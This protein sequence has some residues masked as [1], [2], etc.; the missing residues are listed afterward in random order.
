MASVRSLGRGRYASSSPSIG[1]T[2]QRLGRLMSIGGRHRI[3][4]PCHDASLHDSFAKSGVAVVRDG[5]GN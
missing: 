2:P 3:G 1:S 5:R 4:G